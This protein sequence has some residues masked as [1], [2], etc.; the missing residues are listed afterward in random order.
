MGLENIKR[1]L[2]LLY[3]N[4]HG[5]EIDDKEKIYLIHL[6]IDLKDSTQKKVNDKNWYHR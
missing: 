3:S 5:I 1:R 4:C 6:S 2:N